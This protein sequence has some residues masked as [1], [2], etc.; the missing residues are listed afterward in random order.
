M[1][2]YAATTDVTSDPDDDA[3]DDLFRGPREAFVE[4]RNA[5][6]AR[7]AAAGK[8][9]AAQRVRALRKPSV[10]AWAVNQLWWSHREAYDALHA[11]GAELAELQRSGASI[12][13]QPAN[14]ARRA[15]IDRLREAA[16]QVLRAAGHSASVA[17]LR[18]ISQSL[19]AS[20]A[21]GSFGAHARIGRLETDLSPPG[22][23]QVR[24]FAPEP[25]SAPPAFREAAA[26]RAAAELE[27]TRA[28]RELDDA[29]SVLR[30]AEASAHA[31]AEAARRAQQTLTEAESTLERARARHCAAIEGSDATRARLEELE[32]AARDP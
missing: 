28:S 13:G 27:H 15:A 32:R 12:A 23:G 19:E 22:F 17:T 1:G 26:R 6:A 10:S 30:A 5:L 16:A 2:A 18:K 11:A 14:D 7:L 9:S 31:A 29:T 8:S 21:G 3:I 24:Q 4:A 20:A 25:S